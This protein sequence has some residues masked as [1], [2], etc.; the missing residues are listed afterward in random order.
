MLEICIKKCKTLSMRSVSLTKLQFDENWSY[1]GFG[2][3][4]T[5]TLKITL[6]TYRNKWGYLT[7]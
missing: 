3:V 7:W 6:F 5:E 4:F 1:L 2:K